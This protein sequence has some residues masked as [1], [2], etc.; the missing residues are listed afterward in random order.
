MAD[1]KI[2]GAPSSPD[3]E[4]VLIS[5]TD[6]LTMN[7]KDVLR[8][9]GTSEVGLSEEEAEERLNRFGT[10]EV[11]H[12]KGRR[13]ASKFFSYFLDPLS[14]ILLVAGTL[15]LLTGDQIDAF[16]I[17]VIVIMSSSL[18][19]FQENR[20]EK[21]SEQ[22]T[23]KV[24]IT[25]A[26]V[27]DGKKQ[28]L[29]LSRLV[30]G[31]IVQLSGG[32]I[33]PAE[34]RIILCKDLFIDQSALTGES[35]PVEKMQG[36][37]E[38][39][40]LD[41]PSDWSNYLF[42]GTSVISGSASMVVVRTGSST[43]YA[44]I[45]ERLVERRPMTEFE[46]D[47]RRFGY[48]IMEVTIILVVFVFLV[49]VLDHKDLLISLLFSV[50]LAVGLTPELLPMIITINLSNGALVMSKKDVV[51]KRLESI[52]NYGSMDSSLY[53]QDRYAH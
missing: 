1:T 7:I 30:P 9:V 11:V 44:Q 42:M 2:S 6:V 22:L 4:T 34:G 43:Q 36:S 52:Q 46:E 23:K 12:K 19:Y 40:K 48:L 47:T 17:Y 31:D 5:N 50:A 38:S 20:A 27:R 26:V 29:P 16:I 28:E 25:A 37:L 18:Q 14:L 8:K 13:G 21:A 3:E 33:V 41:D 39:D 49:N 32:D 24:A 45:V 10:N 35:L 51:V 53:R 15:T